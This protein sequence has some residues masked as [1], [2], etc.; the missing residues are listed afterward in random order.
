MIGTG[1]NS[2]WVAVLALAVSACSTGPD[3][4]EW[5]GGLIEVEELQQMLPVGNA[6]AIVDV[7]PETDY[8]EGHIPG[9]VNIWRDEIQRSDTAYR[10]LRIDR[11]A[12]ANLLGTKGISAD[13]LI[14]L[15]DAKG[16]VDA[17]RLWWL[18][19]C[20]GHSRMA[21]LN[22]GLTSWDGDLTLDLAA[23]EPKEFQ[24]V[25]PERPELLIDY[26]E[27]EAVRNR[28]NA[29]I[30]DN[31][32]ES[33]YTG[34]EQKDGAFLAGHIPGAQHFCYS[35]S[36]DF[37]DEG[38]MRFKPIEVL[39]EQYATFAEPEDSVVLYCHSG[40]RS[41]H[42]LFVLTELLDYQHVRNYDGSWIEWS[43]FHQP[44]AADSVNISKL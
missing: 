23:L 17:A 22:G 7:R 37:S 12:L 11:A 33:E 28:S 20:C 29:R 43:F 14:V 39:R 19:K 9:A 15:Y 40:V 3:P 2:V 5:S 25:H 27:F 38:K 6:L 34:K 32:S 4:Q 35:N 41:A 1:W 30:L 36:I 8:L 18:L 21:I 42:T 10:G 13:Q 16:G 31:R 24:F 26:P 44:N